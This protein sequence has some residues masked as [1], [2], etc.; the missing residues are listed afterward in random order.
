MSL[1]TLCPRVTRTTCLHSPCKPSSSRVAR[2]PNSRSL[3]FK[4]F[5]PSNNAEKTLRS[6]STVVH[7]GNEYRYPVWEYIWRVLVDKIKSVNPD[8][9]AEKIASGDYV[10]VDVRTSESFEESHAE[11]AVSAPLFRKLDWSSGDPWQLVRGAAYLV[12]GV[13]PVEQNP[14]FIE[15]ATKAAEGGKGLIVYCEAGGTL[16]PSTNFM[17]GK[18]SRSL[19]AAYRILDAKI[20][21][22]VLHMEGGL[23]GYA[24][25]EKPMIGDYNPENAGKSPNVAAAPEGE[26]IDRKK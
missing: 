19:K 26:F 1:S 21:E 23:Y 6:R 12:N 5:A 3:A 16:Q 24:K 4:P 8:E 11:G 18:T 9:A 15:D 7:A 2:L 17:N 13:Q 20:S 25:M 14:T 22:D 10:F